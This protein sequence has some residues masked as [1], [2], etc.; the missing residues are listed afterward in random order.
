MRLKMDPEKKKHLIQNKISLENIFIGLVILLGIILIINIFLTFDLNKNL[1]KSTEIAKE[2]SR[3]AKIELAVVSNSKCSDCFDI[4]PVINYVKTAKV[5][6]TKETF[7]DM[8]SSQG[9]QLISKYRIEKVPSLI[10][11]GEIDK[12]QVNGVVKNNDALMFAAPE[13]PYTNAAT[14]K[15]EGRVIVYSLSDPQCTKCNDI[16]SFIR[17]IKAAGVKI[18]EQKNI[19]LNSDEGKDLIKKYNIGFAP[20]II[21]SKDAAA[22]EII[23]KA[24]PQIGSK[25]ADGSYVLRVANPPFVNLTTGELRG[26]V[27][28]NYLTDK[29]C[30]DCYDVKQHREILTNPQSFAMHLGKEEIIDFSDAK[31]KELIAAYNVTKVPTVILSK[32][33]GVYPSSQFLKQFF[34]VEKDGSYVFRKLESLGTY[35]D[36]TKNQVV[37]APERTQAQ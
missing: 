21:L 22:Y 6:I 33:A 2:A 11:T 23:Q 34:S 24:W 19:T 30:T 13:P 37:K 36:L 25:E 35:K 8:D 26:I 15:V 1:K 10:I 16:N 12:V 32:E 18:S 9:K 4:S 29:S 3:P 27:D 7:Y 20:A 31:G 28:I 17:Q 5:N 14:G